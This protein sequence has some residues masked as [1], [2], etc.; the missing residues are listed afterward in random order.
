MASVGRAF[1]IAAMPTTTEPEKK[2]LD[3]TEQRPEVAN[4]TDVPTV[5]AA[6]QPHP[7]QPAASKDESNARQANSSTELSEPEQPTPAAPIAVQQKAN[8]LAKANLSSMLQELK[9][10]EEQV[11]DS[12][13]SVTL[14]DVQAAWKAYAE[15]VERDSLRFQ[16]QSAQLEVDELTITVKVGSSLVEGALR[17][18]HGLTDSLRKT[19]KAPGLMLKIEIDPSM[20]KEEVKPNPKCSM[21]A[22]NIS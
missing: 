7:T 17:E 4:V 6:P 18:E 13:E 14:E 11:T 9:A 3:G 16:L 20:R 12:V 2:T 5:G 10:E 22:K 8:T 1:R 15:A 19:L 21:P